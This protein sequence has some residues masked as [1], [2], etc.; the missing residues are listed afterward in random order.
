M[1]N[2]LPPPDFFPFCV[3]LLLN[4]FKASTK[5]NIK[6]NKLE[7]TQYTSFT[8]VIIVCFEAKFYVIPTRAVR[9]SICSLFKTTTKLHWSIW[10]RLQNYFWSSGT[11]WD[12]SRKSQK[13]QGK[14]IGITGLS[15]KER[16]T[17]HGGG[18]WETWTPPENPE[19]QH[20]VIALWVE[21][22][23]QLDYSARWSQE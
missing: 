5:T 10:E 22:E 19:G 3:Y 9:E 1:K 6:H 12:S 13:I 4:S 7:Q 2:I 17:K 11:H 8:L 14:K 15:V 16:C 21:A 23:A 20:Q 18:R